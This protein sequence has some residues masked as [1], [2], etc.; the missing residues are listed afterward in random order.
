M[1]KEKIKNI[2]IINGHSV[3][4]DHGRIHYTRSKKFPEKGYDTKVNK[5]VDHVD[6]VTL[7]SD[8]TFSNGELEFTLHCKSFNTSV[9]AVFNTFV[10]KKIRCGYSS[11]WSSFIITLRE[12]ANLV[13]PQVAAGSLE[14]YKLGEPIRFKIMIQG[15]Q[16]RLLINDIEMCSAIVPIKDSALEFEISS[17]D[18]F[19]ISDIS[20]YSSSSKSAFVVMQFSKEYNELYEEVIKPVIKE[21]GYE[22]KRADEIYTSTPILEDI[23]QSIKE[24]SVVVAEIT[25]DNPNVFYELGYSQAINKPIILLCDRSR[26][27][28]LPFD[29]SGIRTIFYENKIVG[30][31]SV[32]D[33]LRMFLKKI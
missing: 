10:G 21:F 29:I 6:I 2:A 23:R 33:N 26:G 20:V 32:E 13:I 31:K 22:C 18:D 19:E 27:N 15:S 9:L 1:T 8:S 4:V 24:S 28:K 30:K 3:K 7:R 25:P 16:V 12:D 14:N 17:N 5:E 11:L